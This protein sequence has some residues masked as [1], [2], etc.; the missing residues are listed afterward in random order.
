MSISLHSRC[1]A[2]A[3][4]T[5]LIELP[6]ELMYE[7]AE[8]LPRHLDA[9]SLSQASRKLFQALRSR[10]ARCLCIPAYSCVDGAAYTLPV[11]LGAALESL[12]DTRGQGTPQVELRPL[13]SSVRQIR[14]SP[15]LVSRDYVQHHQLVSHASCEPILAAQIAQLVEVCTELDSVVLEDH[16]FSREIASALERRCRIRPFASFV[17]N[18]IAAVSSMS[19]AATHQLVVL[20]G[21][22]T[23]DSRL[24]AG[25]VATRP[26]RALVLGRVTAVGGLPSV[27]SLSMLSILAGHPNASANVIGSQPA[28][29]VLW[30]A[31]DILTTS[32]PTLWQTIRK[33]SCA[34][35]SLKPLLVEPP[36][37]LDDLFLIRYAAKDFVTVQAALGPRAQAV[38]RLALRLGSRTGLWTAADAVAALAKLWRLFPC[39]V[40][41]RVEMWIDASASINDIAARLQS[42]SCWTSS[43]QIAVIVLLSPAPIPR[44]RVAGEPV[45]FS[46]LASDAQQACPELDHFRVD[47]GVGNGMVEL[48]KKERNTFISSLRK[49]RSPGGRRA[50]AGF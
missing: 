8:R 40:D 19:V 33:L 36:L 1:A 46:Q 45:P 34:A 37:I 5:S 25:I 22:A 32:P 14:V 7:V 38:K 47:M 24:A 48:T 3:P 9:L 10:R 12:L 39:L 26:L 20:S 35:E 27:P 13:A 21:H 2:R 50:S 6:P 16:A 18:G 11:D 41:L 31:A 4:A 30:C 29:E 28:L 43:L 42:A 15:R 23:R 17:L 44:V 49:I